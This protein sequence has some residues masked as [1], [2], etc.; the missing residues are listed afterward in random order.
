[1]CAKSERL[2]EREKE[3]ERAVGIEHRFKRERE[4]R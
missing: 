1:M 3:G 4:K 2:R